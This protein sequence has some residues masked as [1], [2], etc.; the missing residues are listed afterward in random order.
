MTTAPRYRR[1][2]ARWRLLIHNM[3]AGGRN[4]TAHHIQSHPRRTRPLIQEEPTERS[5]ELDARMAEIQAQHSTTTILPN[6]EFDELVVGH[7]AHLEQ[8]DTGRWWMSIGGVVLHVH[9]DRDGHPTHVTVHGPGDW[10]G[11]V[12][13]C[14]YRLD[15]SGGAEIPAIPRRSGVAR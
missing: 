9:A 8:E 2:G 14:T 7:F 6:T 3:A 15:W 1:A 11:P 4:G 10:D 5:R 12:P 13:G